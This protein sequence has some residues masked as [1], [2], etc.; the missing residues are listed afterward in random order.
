MLSGHPQIHG[1]NTKYV[2]AIVDAKNIMRK[3]SE[4]SFLLLDFLT[5]IPPD[6]LGCSQASQDHPL[7]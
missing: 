7:L 6:R 5:S 4:T 3:S 1:L 2:A